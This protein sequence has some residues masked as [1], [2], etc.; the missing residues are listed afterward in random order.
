MAS[1]ALTAVTRRYGAVAALDNVTLAFPDRQITAIIGRSGCGKSTLLKLCNGLEVPD[2]GTVELF[3]R[4]L[5][6]T[7]LPR[8][9]R[10]V[11]Y[12]V[13]G[14]GL[15]PHLS[16]RDNIAMLAKLEGWRRPEI[17]QR[18]AELARLCHLQPG[19]LDQYPHQLSGGQQ[20]RIGLCRAMMLR[21]D[22]LL[23]DE[24]FAAI[25][26]VT[27]LDIHAQ[28]ME[29]HVNEP[30]T[31]VLVTHDMAEAL[32][33]ADLIVIMD[34]GRIVHSTSRDA[35]LT[36]GEATEPERLLLDMLG[37]IHP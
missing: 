4:P 37:E 18:V 21:P 27:R 35:L 17:A 22:V 20:Q 6:Y 1:L 12:A 32:R 11:G 36:R 25:D 26:P 9:R 3:G 2:A 13:Q 28:L 34:A 19:Q 7:N 30:T 15:F 16:A 10:R 29:L 31:T 33:L 8:L 5:D 24:P 23:L 14:T